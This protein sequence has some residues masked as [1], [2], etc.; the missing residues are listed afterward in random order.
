MRSTWNKYFYARWTRLFKSGEGLSSRSL[1]A[2]WCFFL[3]I[4]WLPLAA[5]L[6]GFPPTTGLEEN[7][8]PAPI[9]RFNPYDPRAFSAG[10]ERWYA[11][12]FGLRPFLVYANNWIVARIFR[13]SPNAEVQL[14]SDGWFYFT[15]DK[16]TENA[17]GLVPLTKAELDGIVRRMEEQAARMKAR[18]IPYVVL[19]C[20]NKQSVYPE[21]LPSWMTHLGPTRLDQ[22]TRALDGHREFVFVDP[23]AELLRAKGQGPVYMRTDSHW[24][25]WGALVGHTAVLDRLRTR[26]ALGERIDPLAWRIET[27][28]G[29][30]GG[31]LTSS[32]LGLPGAFSDDW[33]RVVPPGDRRLT[34]A[35][36]KVVVFHDSFIT[37]WK[38]FLDSTF[39]Q[40]VLQ[41]RGIRGLDDELVDREK[42]DLVIYEVVERNID[43]FLHPSLR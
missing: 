26:L 8:A 10:F 20:P 38:P 22:V 43:V 37:Q 33:V 1:M 23:R 12:H 17:R 18:G 27:V 19:V 14:G 29:G 13:T 42:P 39:A 2:V 5:Q 31:D 24:N 30:G 32:L 15:S 21:L 11:D 7:R 6:T 40:V 16:S 9:P 35:A 25:P 4:L 28:H 34:P 3:L 36:F 41:H